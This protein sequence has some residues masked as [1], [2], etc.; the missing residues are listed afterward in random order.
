MKTTLFI[1]VR[2]VLLLLLISIFLTTMI[3]HRERAVID[4]S[5]SASEHQFSRTEGTFTITNSLP[6]NGA[7]VNTTDVELKWSVPEGGNDSINYTVYLGKSV[8]NLKNESVT[9]GTSY[10]A[11]GLD[12]D[13]TYYWKI[14][15]DDGN[16]GTITESGIW[17]FTVSLE[18]SAPDEEEDILP[19]IL[20]IILLLIIMIT[21]IFMRYRRKSEEGALK[22]DL[23]GA[24]KVEAD[25]VHVPDTG[26][27]GT[28]FKPQP[29]EEPMAQ[30]IVQPMAQRRFEERLIPMER[31]AP[32][33]RTRRPTTSFLSLLK[34][35]EMLKQQTAPGRRNDDLRELKI[36]LPGEDELD[37]RVQKK[38]EEVLSLPAPRVLEVSEKQQKVPIDELFLINPGGLLVQHYS[39]DRETGLNEDVLAGM[40][41]AVKS[42]MSDSLSMLDKSADAESEINRIDF[43]K[44]SVLM[45]SGKSLSLV[46]I[47]D[48]EKKE[49]IM[50]Q[51]NLCA[52][53]LEKRF[54]G[55]I[56]DWDGDTAKV[57]DIKPV[58]ER[59]V[60]GEFDAD[61]IPV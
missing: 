17:S 4:I 25:I 23:G 38:E 5:R 51:L 10:T 26:T 12:D 27:T 49:E 9:N 41:T 53:V 54:G 40:L 31:R 29:L 22:L 52:K 16:N 45:A 2:T 8:A 60:K 59:M 50:E 19:V 20:G 36:H 32:M 57:E 37:M 56:R 18:N 58:I 48:H 14:I 24:E 61:D 30:P 35:M 44:Y 46:A 15:S 3:T 21:F 47:T 13:V 33:L 43:G 55:I 1:Q 28:T 39:L 34:A 7:V 6:K 11:Q 42:F